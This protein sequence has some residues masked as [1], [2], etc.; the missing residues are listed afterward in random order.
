M[1]QPGRSFL[2]AIFWVI[3]CCSVHA[4]Q[5]AQT[6]ER[7]GEWLKGPTVEEVNLKVTVTNRSGQLVK[8]LTAAD[9]TV[10]E[11]SKPQKIN[12]FSA[13]TTPI[14]L[15]ILVDTSASMLPAQAAL[16]RAV[17]GLTQ[18]S[19]SG[20]EVALISFSD[21]PTLEQGFTRNMDRIYRALDHLVF[22]GDRTL[23]DAVF[24]TTDELRQ[25]PSP[26]KVLV[27]I[28][29]GADANSHKSVSDI[30]RNLEHRDDWIVYV[31]GFPGNKPMERD[32]QS[33]LQRLCNATGGVALF[34]D[35]ADKLEESSRQIAREI[36]HQYA[37]GY[38]PS[39]PLSTGGYRKVKVEAQAPRLQ[40]LQ[41]RTRSGYAASEK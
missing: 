3:T 22:R 30:I 16:H 13:E 24:I 21:E 1:Q 23:Y 12:Y 14:T 40:N 20:N 10:Y 31:L 41:V 39:N 7:D 26:K 34:L 36:G 18:E 27:V 38:K 9:F 5:S 8:D 4:Q 19:N 17:T 35:S 32:A 11:D 28:T 29:G 33:D 6:P 37:I 2:H 25:G 15:A